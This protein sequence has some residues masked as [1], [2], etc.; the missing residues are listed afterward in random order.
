MDGSAR[1]LDHRVAARTKYYVHQTAGD[2]P[3]RLIEFV[4]RRHVPLLRVMHT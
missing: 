2:A 3:E 4:S 1:N